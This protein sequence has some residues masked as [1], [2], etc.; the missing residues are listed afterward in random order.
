MSNF[1]QR[2]PDGVQVVVSDSENRVLLQ[3][4]EDFRLWSLPGGKIEPGETPEVAAVRELQEETGFTVSLTR[5]VGFYWR[6]DL[7]GGGVL[8][9]VFAGQIVEKIGEPG[10]ESVAVDWFTMETL[11]RSVPGWTRHVLLDTSL[12]AAP[13]RRIQ[14]LPLWKAWLVRLLYALRRLRN[15]L[16]GRR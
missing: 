12:N 7:P 5:C 4:R 10:W 8:V 3:K 16:T 1:P 14:R 15:Q 11:P 2:A 9:Q 13:V 6:P